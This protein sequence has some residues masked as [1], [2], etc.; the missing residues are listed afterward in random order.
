MIYNKND[1]TNG[2]Y[3]KK[4]NEK[5][6][7]KVWNFNG[8]QNNKIFINNLFKNMMIIKNL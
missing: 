1:M 6:Q 3:K 7:K 4:Q 2:K 5:Q 8:E